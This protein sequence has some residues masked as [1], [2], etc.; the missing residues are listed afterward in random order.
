LL[1]KFVLF[2]VLLAA[3]C[4]IAG[5]YGALHDQISYTVSPD[6]FFAFKFH[7][8]E[9]P[10]HLQ[11][12]VGAA[13]VGWQ[14]SWWMGLL[15]GPPVLVVAMIIPGWKAYVT[16]SL[17]ALGVVALTTLLVGLGA[18]VW[19]TCTLTAEHLPEFWYPEG[20]VDRVAFARVGIMHNFSY[21]G[22][23][24]GIITGTMYLIIERIRLSLRKPPG[25]GQI[26]SAVPGNET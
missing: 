8:F 22:G 12:R 3:A 15:I 7:Q 18:L 11:G 21:L 17:L 4:V 6:Y 1:E 24:I 5:A 14:A 20:P 25:P 19:A 23:F 10:T 16:R 9:I 2:F 13:I 26:G